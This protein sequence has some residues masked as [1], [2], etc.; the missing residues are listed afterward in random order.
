VDIAAICYIIEGMLFVA[1]ST[2]A[3][4]VWPN[5]FAFEVFRVAP[6]DVETVLA[7]LFY[8]LFVFFVLL[9]CELFP[10][11]I[12]PHNTGGVILSVTLGIP[13]KH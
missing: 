6:G 9:L 3:H 8:L 11:A 12:V 13:C 7:S 10:F 4:G 1:V 2:K 5:N